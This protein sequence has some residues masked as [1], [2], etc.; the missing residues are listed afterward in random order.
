[1]A[2]SEAPVLHWQPTEDSR[3][4]FSFNIPKSDEVLISPYN[5]TPE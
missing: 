1:M 2:D 3:I 4:I 5:I